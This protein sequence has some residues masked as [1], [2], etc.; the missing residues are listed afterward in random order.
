MWKQGTTDGHYWQA[1]V[2]AEPSQYGIGGGRVSKLS[3]CNADKVCVYYY[4]RG[5]DFDNAAVG[6]LSAVL[7][8]ATK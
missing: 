8:A 6:V 2:F 5:L 3:I 4:D 1:K 7:E